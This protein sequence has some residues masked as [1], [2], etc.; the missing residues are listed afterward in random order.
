MS[1][2]RRNWF[3]VGLAAAVALAW[4]CPAA[5]ARG[6]LLRTEVTARAA[7][8]LIFFFQG[9]TLSFAALKGGVMR[10]RLHALVQAW[11]FLLFPLT[12]VLF[13]RVAG[14]LL[15]PDL[16]LGFL[17]LCVLP[18][19][20][21]TAIVFTAVA[22]GNTAGAVF[23]ATLSNLL[24]IALTPLWTRWLMQAGGRTLP[25]GPV[26]LDIALLLLA[27]LVA[28]QALRPWLGRWA[29]ARRSRLAAVNSGIVLFIVY[30][31][32]AGSVQAG[33]WERYG[34]AT[35]AR[36]V[37]GVV[38]LFGFIMAAVG[39]TVRAAGLERSDAVAGLFCASQKTLAAGVPMAQLI[40]GGDPGLG[41][42]LLPVM[43][44]HP[45]QLT[46]HGLLATR[47]SRAPRG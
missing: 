19:T 5:G 38:V 28:G 40:F 11:I 1:W 24:G 45:L 31:A 14:G 8:A 41:L 18:T 42:I 35:T 20:V 47:W 22:G 44:Y 15:P 13:T 39:L 43:L 10:W 37:V 30:A 33:V 9:L 6:G 3:V 17:F 4:I 23:N 46:V 7:V 16:R 2:L 27:P 29:D 32:F 26:I 25:L 36:A 34:A 12:G 21:S